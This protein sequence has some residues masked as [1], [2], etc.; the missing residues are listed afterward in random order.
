[1]QPVRIS[2][3]AE[4]MVEPELA[5]P[6]ELRAPLG[7][8]RLLSTMALLGVATVVAKCIA[9]GKDL[10]V[11]RQLGAGD[12]LDAYLVALVLPSYAAVVLGHTFASAFVPT[13]VRVWQQRGLAP[14]Q[15]LAGGVL[16]A[17]IVL[18]AGVSLALCA[19]APLVL[20]LIGMGFDPQKLALARELFYLLAGIVLTTGVS[21]VVAA[22]LN[23]HERFVA[24]ALAPVAI[25]IGTLVTF[26]VYGNTF[27]VKALAVGTLLGFI[28]ELAVL[29]V[30]A[31]RAGL[32]PWPQFGGAIGEISQV[33]TQYLPAALGGLLMSSSLVIDQAMAASLGSG[34]VSVL[35]FGG[36]VV[37][38]VLGVVAVS[39][40]TVL[41]PNFA[42]QI[43]AG[44]TRELA[45]TF[46]I[47]AIGIFV[48]SIPA[49]AILALFTEPLV[50]LLF[51]RGAFTPDD[52]MAVSRVQLWLLPQ[53]PFYVLAILGARV[54][55][56]L[57]G[58]AVVLRIAAIN[59]A[60]NV[61]GNYVLMRWYGVAGI[62]MSTSL[63]YVVAMLATL[64]AIRRKLVE[65]QS[66]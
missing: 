54:L 13:Y 8:R 5:S 40:S 17:A 49:V 62:A 64:W 44:R 10:L 11:A 60:M 23:A 34:Q 24:I 47:Y 20:P 3:E 63:M 50:R 19:I 32:S 61:L 6:P 66:T 12:E 28:G 38:V 31:W 59:L 58:N 42:H 21:A 4:L 52:T 29:I 15:Q 18:L 9:L 35:N 65:R 36:K 14:A 41:F 33:A 46:G 27:G 39:I 2:P 30:A 37:A 56:A 51:E 25:P 26:G 48:V 53:I 16:A 57:D 55:S 22:V 43:A 1:V 45:R 7:H